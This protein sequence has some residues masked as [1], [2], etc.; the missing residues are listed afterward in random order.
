M[1]IPDQSHSNEISRDEAVP[2]AN[3]IV[4]AACKGALYSSKEF[5]FLKNQ[6]MPTVILGMKLKQ[7]KKT[8]PW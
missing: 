2:T 3:T 8:Q 4:I 1:H 7:A 5:V 6:T